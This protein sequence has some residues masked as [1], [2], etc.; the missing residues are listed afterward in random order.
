[1]CK[2]KNLIHQRMLPSVSGKWKVKIFTL[3]SF[4]L[5]DRPNFV[6]KCRL[7]E[8]APTLETN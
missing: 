8:E 6:V 2:K 3:A 7:L 5:V 4:V 1:M